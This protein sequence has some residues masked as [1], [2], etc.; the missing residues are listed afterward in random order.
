MHTFCSR[1][2]TLALL[3]AAL[4]L[5]LAL[6]RMSPTT[7][8]LNRSIWG[9]AL[10]KR[11]REVWFADLPP[12]AVTPRDEDAARWFTADQEAKAQFDKICHTQF[13][14]ALESIGPTKYSI[15]ALSG[16]EAIKPFLPEL[17][18]PDE[19]ENSRTVLSLL[20]LLDQV[21]RNLFR[22]KDTLPLVYKQY[23]P[24]ALSL[25][26]H[27]LTMNPRPDKHPSFRGAVV[28]KQWLYMPLMHS[29]NVEDH[30]LFDQVLV[31]SAEEMDDVGA[32]KYFQVMVDFEKQHREIIDRFGRYPH[33]NGAMGRETTKEEEEWLKQGGATFGVAG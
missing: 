29:E 22:T 33:R 2:I 10:Y 30:K 7:F 14:T 11:V 23:D 5:A 13:S 8:A 3:V 32:K 26:K 21:P 18:G 12:T 31:E 28:Y 6:Y 15:T 27:I 16:E 20:L 9:P 19:E 17:Q 25:I 24:I 1:P 4:S